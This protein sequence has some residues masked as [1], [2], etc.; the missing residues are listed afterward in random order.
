MAWPALIGAA[1]ACAQSPSG[2]EPPPSALSATAFPSSDA[3]TRGYP[4]DPERLAALA[5]LL[6]LLQFKTEDRS[7]VA[8]ERQMDYRRTIARLDP[9]PATDDQ[10]AAARTL[11]GDESFQNA[12]VTEFLPAYATQAA[13]AAAVPRSLIADQGL[14]GVLWTALAAGIVAALLVP[15][16]AGIRSRR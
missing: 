14:W 12:V 2:E 11:R 15:I 8:L 10:R 5:V 4:S 3:V 7:A 1:V 9:P 6:D 13:R 16:V